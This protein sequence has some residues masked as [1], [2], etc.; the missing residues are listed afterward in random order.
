MRLA[1]RVVISH[2]TAEIPN[3]IDHAQFP[4]RDV[5]EENGGRHFVVGEIAAWLVEQ[6]LGDANEC[7]GRGKA[8]DRGF[9]VGGMIVADA[10]LS[11]A[12]MMRLV[13]VSFSRLI[14]TF[15]F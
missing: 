2:Y 14:S 11:G 8:N 13:V 12:V 15:Q 9:G 10:L 5:V 1:T 6:R 4:A 7:I 3:L